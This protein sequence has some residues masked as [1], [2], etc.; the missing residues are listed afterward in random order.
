[1]NREDFF[2]SLDA[3]NPPEDFTPGLKVLWHDAQEDWEA[4]HDIAQDMPDTLGSW[5]HGYLHLKEGDRWNAAYWYRQ[6]NQP[7]PES[8]VAAEFNRLLKYLLNA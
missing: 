7:F 4:A 5:L 1:M 2:K 8:G 3:G 6:A